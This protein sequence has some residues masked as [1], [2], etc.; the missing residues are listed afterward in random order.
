MTDLGDDGL[1]DGTQGARIIDDLTPEPDDLVVT[2]PRLTG[3]HGTDLDVLLRGRGIDTVLFTGVATNLS[4]EGTARE[5]V[6]HGY[7]TLLVTDACSAATDEAH[8]ATLDTF[9]LLGE[10]VTT[11]TIITAFANKPQEAHA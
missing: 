7:R 9:G 5:A 3:F 1:Q 11:D 2:H 8:R 10:A 4:V 6:N